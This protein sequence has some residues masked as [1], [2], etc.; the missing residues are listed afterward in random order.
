MVNPL[1]DQ[2]LLEQVAKEHDVDPELAKQ[3]ILTTQRVMDHEHVPSEKRQ[4]LQQA[5]G[6]LIEEHIANTE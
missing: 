3:L 1:I 5:I 4:A 2:E 6:D